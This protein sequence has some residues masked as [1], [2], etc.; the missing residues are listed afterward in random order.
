MGAGGFGGSLKLA[1]G[2]R[3][4]GSGFSEAFLLGISVVLVVGTSHRSIFPARIKI[5][6]LGNEG[7]AGA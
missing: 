4:R 5:H 1:S 6:G 7:F 3:L 2:V